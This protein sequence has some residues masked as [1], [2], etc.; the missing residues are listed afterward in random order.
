MTS[1][2]FPESW[3]RA[4]NA[5]LLV[6]RLFV[7]AFL[8]WGVWDNIISTERMAE[9]AGFLSSNRFPNPEIMAP[10][11][12]GVQFACGLSFVSGAMVRWAGVL[13]AI[14]FVVALVMVDI[15][16]GWR[17][18]FPAMMLILFGLYLAARG[19]GR[20]SFDEL[21]VKRQYTNVIRD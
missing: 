7:G 9:F 1:L 2:L 12:V 21:F 3:S 18:A 15:Q 4:E 14:N 8:I 16:G 5:T 20:Y 19:G 10:V 11:S 13:C 6:F 17:S